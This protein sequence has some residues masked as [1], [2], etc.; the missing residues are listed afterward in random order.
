[1]AD[2]SVC[3]TGA[4]GTPGAKSLNAQG[5]A[6][7]AS[8]V[9][10]GHTRFSVLDNGGSEWESAALIEKPDSARCAR[11]GVH[12][13]GGFRRAPLVA[14]SAGLGPAPPRIA[15]CFSRA[16]AVVDV[17]SVLGLNALE[18]DAIFLR[19]SV[20]LL[21]AAR[22]NKPLFLLP[23]RIGPFRDATISETA[24][25][26]LGAAR[27]VWAWD[28]E[29]FEQ[30]RTLLGSAFDPSRHQLGAD[31]A[32]ALWSSPVQLDPERLPWFSGQVDRDRPPVIGIEVCGNLAPRR[33]SA[34]ERRTGARCAQALADIIA[35][36]LRETSA[37]LLI[38]PSSNNAPQSEHECTALVERAR[39]RGSSRQ[40]TRIAVFAHA[41]EPL[42]RRWLHGR[43]DWFCGTS[44]DALTSAL[45]AGT[46]TVGLITKHAAPAALRACCTAE[47]LFDPQSLSASELRSGVLAHFADR[48]AHRASLI[49]TV[50]A[51]R[52]R[53]RAEQKALA[54]AIALIGGTQPGVA[55][56]DAPDTGPT[57]AGG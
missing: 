10:A 46:P 14:R 18:D 52:R 57:L 23:R 50:A 56:K 3:I 16:D 54:D 25:E 15:D 5:L 1:M 7:L 55:T 22:T 48:D 35:T 4:T 43:L 39:P 33:R 41:L 31:P 34:Q 13:Q 32:F 47:S 17:S 51:L 21:L 36:M 42:E 49:V 11:D 28:A 27:M 45:S 12:P 29:N 19:S 6:T 40:R 38:L 20:P 26:I 44:E 53:V 30:M 24:R 9:R 2:A 8:I 37:N